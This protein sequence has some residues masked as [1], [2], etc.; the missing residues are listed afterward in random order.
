MKKFIS[1]LLCL[2]LLLTAAG[3][4]VTTPEAQ[5]G[6]QE[7]DI[8]SDAI[9]TSERS[10][11]TTFGL[12]YAPAYGL[13]P[14]ACTDLAN[15]T[16]ISLLYESLFTVT[17]NFSVEPVLCDTYKVSEDQMTYTI[18][19]LDGVCFADGSPLT[20]PDVVASY[21]AAR[22]SA[23]YGTR[24][25]YIYSV[26]AV[27]NRT[28]QFQLG[29]PYENL[30]LIL[31]VPIVSAATVESTTPMGTGPYYTSVSETATTLLP[32]EHWWQEYNPAV[33]VES[34]TLVET[35]SP[36]AIRDD[37]EYG[38]T[39]VVCTDPNSSA[40]ADYH[41]DYELWNC[42]TTI[43]DFIGFNAHYGMFSDANLRAAFTYIIDRETIATDVY[44]GYAEPAVLPC[45]P[46]SPLY[47]HELAAEYDFDPARF[48]AVASTFEGLG[49]A[50]FLVCSSDPGR[51]AA[52]QVIAD[53]AAEYGL[54]LEIVA[55][56]TNEFTY[57]VYQGNYDLYYGQVRLAPNFDLTNFFNGSSL[58]NGGIQ[59][60]AIVEQCKAALENNG[61]YYNLF[62][63]V[64][65][66]GAICPVLFKAYAVYATR[67]IITNM[68][69]AVDN[70]FHTSHGRPITDAILV[71]E[72]TPVE[73][74]G[75]TAA[76]EAAQTDPSAEEVTPEETEAAETATES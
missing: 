11:V 36:A 6:I 56:P 58:S 60:A 29:T 3:C 67:G 63:S 76:E 52:A 42:S 2:T 61:N 31:D 69:P 10:E 49:T 19:L 70:V 38:T 48:E 20:A 65:D 9:D 8:I 22:D 47:E 26:T 41:C 51:V 55:R 17:S 14:Y 34:I 15:R 4:G 13:N 24:M 50:K 21:Q 39:G 43:M 18:T 46:L 66:S 28:V 12:S 74:T 40:Y 44:E 73:Q 35:D 7:G 68:I 25:M 72:E 75:E 45:N 32:N 53:T 57:M 5:G 30:P 23:V 27:D 37:F 64:V 62:E 33:T 16:I 59:N 71:E 54:E 1:L